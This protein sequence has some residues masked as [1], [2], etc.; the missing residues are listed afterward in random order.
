MDEKVSV[1][2]GEFLYPG[3]EDPI[4]VLDRSGEALR[5]AGL[6]FQY[7]KGNDSLLHYTLVD[8]SSG[9][10]RMVDIMRRVQ[11]LWTKRR[12]PGEWLYASFLGDF[13]VDAY[14]RDG[15]GRRLGDSGMLE[16]REVCLRVTYNGRALL[17]RE[18][19][20]L[21]FTCQCEGLLEGGER[22]EHRRN[23]KLM[24][25]SMLRCWRSTSAIVGW[26][27][28]GERPFVELPQEAG[29][30]PLPAQAWFAVYRKESSPRLM[31]DPAR[32]GAELLI[33]EHDDGTTL[34]E[35]VKNRPGD[36]GYL[37]GGSS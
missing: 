17:G 15:A 6:K 33:K 30:L 36:F 9:V 18:T 10:R 19:Y 16:L 2:R 14:V 1:L 13:D 37:T 24:I 31:Q 34:V 21:V 11:E 20:S 4:S 22:E 8:W 27:S 25:D 32:S 12:H 3:A 23:L 35:N 29:E 28:V 7:F 26:V 5:A